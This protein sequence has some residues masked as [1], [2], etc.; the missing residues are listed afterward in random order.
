MQFTL[1]HL[2]AVKNYRLS[3]AQQQREHGCVIVSR[4]C[5]GSAPCECQ[6]KLVLFGAAQVDAGLV[7]FAEHPALQTGAPGERMRQKRQHGMK[8]KE[9][10]QWY[11]L[12][13]P[14]H[15]KLASGTQA[16]CAVSGCSQRQ[17][18]AQSSVLA[19]PCN[20]KTSFTDPVSPPPAYS[21]FP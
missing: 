14:T 4:P 12:L 8:N 2:V 18:N 1:K 7:C 9:F 3:L 19:P 16:C 6:H 20:S 21:S 13:E 15:C 5:S 17:G 10:C 11:C